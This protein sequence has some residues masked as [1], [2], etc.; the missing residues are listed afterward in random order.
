[1][2]SPI[3]KHFFV[4]LFAAVHAAED[5]TISWRRAQGAFITKGATAARYIMVMYSMAKS[6]C[7]GS[8][9]RKTRERNTE[10]DLIEANASWAP[11]AY[12]WLEGRKKKRSDSGA[13]EMSI[14]RGQGGSDFRLE[15][16]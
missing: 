11:C 2:S 14:E 7:R 5:A 4:S 6:W 9:D 1:M 3:I 10:P 12:G 16:A 8:W 15:A 13:A